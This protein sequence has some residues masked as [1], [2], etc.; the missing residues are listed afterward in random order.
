MILLALKGALFGAMLYAVSGAFRGRP[1]AVISG[2][3]VM[4]G[5]CVAAA[6]LR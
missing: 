2:L 3:I 6:V 1:S 4:G 5:L